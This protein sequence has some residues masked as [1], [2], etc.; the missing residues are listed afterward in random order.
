[1]QILCSTEYDRVKREDWQ[2]NIDEKHLLRIMESMREVG[3]IPALHITMDKHWNLKVGQHRFEASRRLGIPFYYIIEENLT[4]ERMRRIES[5]SK[6]WSLEDYTESYAA[7][8]RESYKRLRDLKKET[9]IS[10]AAILDLALSGWS[11][12]RGLDSPFFKGDLDFNDNHVAFV[13][14]VLGRVLEM[15]A[16]W[17]AKKDRALLRVMAILTRDNRY[18]HKRMLAK[19]EMQRAKFVRAPNAK[20]YLTMLTDIYNWSSKPQYRVNFDRKG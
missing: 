10:Y 13:R 16:Y 6:N 2:R 5:L 4:A 15:G 20:M 8:G 18:N 14:L 11:R 1:M 19:L 12:G 9:G 17:D 7:S 3:F